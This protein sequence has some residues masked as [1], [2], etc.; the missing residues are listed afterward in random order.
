[1]QTKRED[2]E[3]LLEDIENDDENLPRLEKAMNFFCSNW[4]IC[5]GFK[6]ALRITLQDQYDNH[7][8]EQNPADLDKLSDIL[9]GAI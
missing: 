4:D 8:D 2:I 7:P 6:E 5:E 9:N 3:K 1:M